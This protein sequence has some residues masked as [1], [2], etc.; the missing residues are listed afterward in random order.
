MLGSES[1]KVLDLLS[2]HSTSDAKLR[3]K[4]QLL[5]ESKRAQKAYDRHQLVNRFNLSSAP[6]GC[7]GG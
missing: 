7:A 6:S 2:K 5:P 4:L 3:L 1:P